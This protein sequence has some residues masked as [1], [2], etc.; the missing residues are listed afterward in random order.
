M[1]R[2]TYEIQ[3]AITH[4]TDFLIQEQQPDGTWR[5][6]FENGTIIDAYMIILLRSINFQNETI[7]QQLHHRIAKEQ[8]QKGYW[9]LYEDEENG[10]LTATIDNYFAL[11]YSGYSQV[12]DEHMLLAKQY[13]LSNGGITS[14]KGLL[15]KSMLAITGQIP[16]PDAISSIPIE[17]IL[18]PSYLP[19]NLFE[20]SGYS[21]IHLIPMLIMAKLEFHMDSPVQLN[22]LIVSNS[23]RDTDEHL[24]VSYSLMQERINS[25][26]SRLI[27]SNLNDIAMEKAAEFMLARIEG[28]GTLYSYASSTVLMIFALLALGYDP[29]DPL[30]TDAVEGLIQMSSIS[31]NDTL[32]IQNSPST[33]WDTAL[34]SY[35]LQQANLSVNHPG[36]H[37]ANEYLILKQ[38]DKKGDWSIHNKDVAPGGWGFSESN[39]I[40]PDI[41]DTTA[42]LRAIYNAT[43]HDETYLRAT[44]LGLDWIVSMQNKDGGWPAFE[45]NVDNKMLTWLALD[46][47]KAAAIDPSTADLTGRTLEYLGNYSKLNV[48]D[49]PIQRGIKWLMN[50]QEKD[51]SWYG[52][53]GI[54]YIYGTWAALTGLKSVGISSNHQSVQKAV[55]WLTSIQNTDGG[56]GESCDSDRSMRYTPL[57]YSTPSQTAW[58]LDALIAVNDEPT[59]EINKAVECLMALINNVSWVTTYPTGA[60]LPGNFYVHYH[61]YRYIYPLLA[62]SHY[63]KKY[64]S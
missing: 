25:S 13:I 26:C 50:N 54:C 4:L 14:T 49:E 47:A 9:T 11:L 19:I 43:P 36:I 46:G 56:W 18:L 15:S 34:I 44:K 21:R 37:K 30:I 58:A 7:I 61:S 27:G 62:L 57:H 10:D 52:K 48:E 2:D 41:D 33:I 24:S 16:W 63:Q 5:F 38:H 22:E 29:D 6:C 3:S 45:K 39:T 64:L 1:L 59:A 53:W 8:N 17:F 42:A 35:A 51:G 31:S 20:F 32:T 28:D 23:T 40:N 12:D 55:K 60:G